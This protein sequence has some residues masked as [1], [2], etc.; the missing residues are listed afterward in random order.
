MTV[1]GAHMLRERVLCQSKEP[2]TDEFGVPVPG[3]GQFKTRF[4]VRAGLKP[5]NGG[6]VVLAGRL[7]GV[8]PY[9]L[10]VRQDQYTRQITTSWRLVDANDPK[11]IFAIRSLADPDN[12]RQW[13]E[14]LVSTGDA[15]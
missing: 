9:I 12:K 1:R 10:T 6:E 5:R 3:G 8:Q 14:L 4:S 13:L 15:A 7:E 11:R 2:A